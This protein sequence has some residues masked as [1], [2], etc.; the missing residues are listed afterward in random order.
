MRQDARVNAIAERL[1]EH[2]NGRDTAPLAELCTQSVCVNSALLASDSSPFSVQQGSL[3]DVVAACDARFPGVK[4]YPENVSVSELGLVITCR[5]EFT[6]DESNRVIKLPC[7]CR[8]NLE[9][10]KIREIWF[11]VDDYGLL[12]QRGRSRWQD[13]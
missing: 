6:P 7:T 4:F 9:R 8:V 2:L 13:R 1:V 10:E 3:T 11:E 12:L 5:G